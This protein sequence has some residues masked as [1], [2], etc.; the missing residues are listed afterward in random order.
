MRL[1]SFL[2][3]VALLTPQAVSAQTTADGIRAL[4]RSD[5]AAAAQI[6]HP[7]A[8]DKASP[9]PIAQFFM[10]ELYK[11]GLGVAADDLRAC[12]L[13]KSASQSPA[14]RPQALALAADIH[15]D[16]PLLLD[17]C[18]TRRVDAETGAA[19]GQPAGA[20][21]TTLNDGVEAWLR[22][23]YQRAAD[24]LYPLAAT[25]EVD[26]IAAFFMA[27]MYHSGQGVSYDDIRA[28]AL[29]MKAEGRAP[30]LFARLA[31]ELFRSWHM[32]TDLQ[33]RDECSMLASVG[34]DHGFQ[35][36]TFMLGPG[37]SISVDIEGATIDY[38]GKQTRL[39]RLFELVPGAVHLPA[40][41][42]AL[43]TRQ[44]RPARRDFIELFRW[45]PSQPHAA[46]SLRWTLFEVIRDDVMDITS[47]DLAAVSSPR[48]PDDLDY[49]E[50][51]E[52]V[53]NDAGEA[54]WVVHTGDQRSEFI[55]SEEERI[56]R[57]EQDRAREAADRAFDWSRRV[58]ASRA[59]RLAYA[60]TE[61]CANLYVFGRSADRTEVIRVRAERNVLQLATE[62]RTFEIGSHAPGLEVTVLVYDR[63]VGNWGC[64]DVRDPGPSPEPWTAV[65]GTV[66]VQLLTGQ[67]RRQPGMY[68][69]TVQIVGA[70]FVNATGGRVRQTQP[71]VFTA[72]I[73]GGVSG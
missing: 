28:C 21:H 26:P 29:Y 42:T 23:D 18:Q 34:F 58:D 61:G 35:P 51:A 72:V 62:P 60:D 57:H 48:P 67:L 38:Q 50:L 52:V 54:E 71:I 70:E 15:L 1:L 6:L 22:G 25:T 19:P 13:F 8:E 69:A 24:T 64:S 11:W 33:R 53:V 47:E 68:R 43:S 59:P 41:H 10:A 20:V 5:Y 7:L 65:A 36:L 2:V 37:H 30:P 73:V 63:P 3:V 40:R 31:N 56:A 45:Q 9:D 32:S 66:S 12:G 46:W 14:V 16:H 27:M 44:P 49:R 55:E 4:I 17:A 39:D